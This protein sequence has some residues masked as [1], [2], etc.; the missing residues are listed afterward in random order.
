ML[1]LN[2]WSRCHGWYGILI[3]EVVEEIRQ[4]NIDA[5][6]GGRILAAIELAKRCSGV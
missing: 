6:A 4:D 5:F 1:D 2:D 3:C